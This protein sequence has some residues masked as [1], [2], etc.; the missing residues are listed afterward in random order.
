MTSAVGPTHSG[1]AQAI[2]VAAMTPTPATVTNGANTTAAPT[3]TAT[4]ATT[5]RPMLPRARFLL[6]LTMS[7]HSL[8]RSQ[9]H[10][11]LP[12]GVWEGHAPSLGRAPAGEHRRAHRR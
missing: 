6:L 3:K 5:P 2:A 9:Q 8:R 7:T 4:S 1:R 10:A 11:C 12:T